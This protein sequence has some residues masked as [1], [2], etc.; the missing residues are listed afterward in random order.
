[1]KTL[2]YFLAG[3]LFLPTYSVFAQDEGPQD[4][5]PV[6]QTEETETEEVTVESVAAELATATDPAQVTAIMQSAFSNSE[7]SP[8][9]IGSAVGLAMGLLGSDGDPSINAT[10]GGFASGLGKSSSTVGQAISAGQSVGSTLKANGVSANGATKASLTR[11]ISSG[12]TALPP[13]TG[14]VGGGSSSNSTESSNTSLIQSVQESDANVTPPST[15]RLNL[16]VNQPVNLNNPIGDPD[17]VNEIDGG[18][19]QNPVSPS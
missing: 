7:L 15:N 2:L 1:M 14:F 10:L 11:A 13:T 5:T 9:Q 17:P 12:I 4:D 18:S 6:E 16:P 8:E 19:T 3:A